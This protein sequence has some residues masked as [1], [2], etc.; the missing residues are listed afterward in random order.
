MRWTWVWVNLGS[1]WWTGRPGV[2]RFMGSQSVGHNWATLLNWTE[3]NDFCSGS[4]PHSS[5]FRSSSVTSLRSSE[6]ETHGSGECARPKPP[7]L[8]QCREKKDAGLDEAVS[9]HQAKNMSTN[10]PQDQGQ[11]AERFRGDQMSGG[12]ARVPLS[13]VVAGLR[14]LRQEEGL[15]HSSLNFWEAFLR[16]ESLRVCGSFGQGRGQ[17]QD[18]WLLK[19]F[20]QHQEDPEH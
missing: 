5:W 17:G 3:L 11:M 19:G 13:L 10:I 18:F 8:V 12:P 6:E 7:F 2:L 20:L 14:W 1:W 9:C 16:L 15:K 4:T